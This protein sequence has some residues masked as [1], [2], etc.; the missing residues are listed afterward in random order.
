MKKMLAKIGEERC[1]KTT[2]E[3]EVKFFLTCILYFGMTQVCK[4][5]LLKR[6]HSTTNVRP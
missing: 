6:F 5:S 2:K 1:N 3:L 4:L